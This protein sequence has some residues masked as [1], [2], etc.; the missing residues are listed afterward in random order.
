MA[1]SKECCRQFHTAQDVADAM[2]ISLRQFYRLQ[3]HWQEKRMLKTGK[4][5]LQLGRRTRR[6]DLEAMLELARR[7]GY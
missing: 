5:V 4:H 6:Y 3:K 1:D 7:F 2:Q